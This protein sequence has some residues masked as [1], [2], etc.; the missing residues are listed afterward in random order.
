MVG[1]T[2]DDVIRIH[3]TSMDENITRS[4]KSAGKSAEQASKGMTTLQNSA[5]ASFKSFDNL[6]EA[7]DDQIFLLD[8]QKQKAAE[9]RNNML[10]L[11]LALLFTGMALGKLGKTSLRSL[12]KTYSEVTENQTKLGK[13][14]MGTQA[15]FEFL[16]F[17]IIDAF[18][19]ADIGI[20]L[21]DLL[22][23]VLNAVSLFV[24][25]HPKVAQF[26][27]VFLAIVAVLGTV[28]MVL[29]QIVLLGVGLQVT[30]FPLL[31]I[32]LLVGLA[33]AALFAIWT[34]DL[35]LSIKILLTFATILLGIGASI[36]ILKVGVVG[37]ISIM[38]KG[39]FFL[40]TN[41]VVL[42]IAALI[43][44]ITVIALM[45]DAMGGFGNFAKSVVAGVGKL[46]LSLANFAI[47]RVIDK[48][49]F[50]I[51]L[52]FRI[53]KALGKTGLANTLSQ[54]GDSL[55]GFEIL[56]DNAFLAALEK[57]DDFTGVDV[58]RKNVAEGDSL[59]KKL[60]GISFEGFEPEG[61]EDF[62]STLDEQ[63]AQIEEERKALEDIS[64]GASLADLKN[65][66][67]E[68]NRLLADIKESEERDF[69]PQISLNINDEEIINK[70]G[71]TALIKSIVG[72]V[73]GD[74]DKDLGTPQ[75]G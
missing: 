47:Q 58:A 19:A 22:T 62:A 16:K 68:G 60:T 5:S 12:F 67:E 10:G 8:R 42:L 75:S 9:V 23:R 48:F 24:A 2:V 44:V 26:L 25:Q 46:F 70:E 6:N 33:S 53:A 51:N 66:Q 69:S 30:F 14:V 61:L 65:L 63:K 37:F 11:G 52:G 7:L 29:G 38:A 64:G 49:K 3:F 18:G 35:P 1:F 17:S 56:K 40:A 59:L 73:I 21:L 31:S 57:I 54:I 36:L 72:E 55:V 39:F 74:F 41:P 13:K 4:L 71:F 43:G 32:I 45:S 50:L 15:A 27:V 34:S 28:T 20:N